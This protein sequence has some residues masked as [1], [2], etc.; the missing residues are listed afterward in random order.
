MGKGSQDSK[1]M[2]TNGDILGRIIMAKSTEQ[3]NKK[4]NK[5]GMFPNSRKNLEKGGHL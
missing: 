1:E 2:V 4:G 3:L 5:R